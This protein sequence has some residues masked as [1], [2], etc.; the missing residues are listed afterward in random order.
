MTRQELTDAASHLETASESAA[1]DAKDRLSELADQLRT[2]A[3]RDRGPDHG[4]LARIQSALDE[5]RD[6]VDDAADAAI[7]DAND[8]I[9]SFRETLEGV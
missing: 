4:R 8:A 1:D 3:E 7:D 2:L 5:L 9:N 6:D